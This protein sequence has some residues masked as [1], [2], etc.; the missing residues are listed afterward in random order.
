M[1]SEAR[2]LLNDTIQPV[3]YSDADLYDILD[4]A[5]GV[6]RRVRPDLFLGSV[7]GLRSE[8]API[9]PADANQ[10]FP[11]DWSYTSAFVWY[12]AGRAEMR[13]DEFSSDQRATVLLARFVAEMVVH[14]P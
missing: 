4:N 13:D 3:R 8:P 9:A 1:I 2:S 11:L 6:T 5:I 7:A 10:P 12:V 14:A